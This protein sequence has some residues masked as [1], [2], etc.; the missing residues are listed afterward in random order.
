MMYE[1]IQSGWKLFTKP[2]FGG[3]G[4]VGH[5]DLDDTKPI[6]RNVRHPRNPSRKHVREDVGVGIAD[7]GEVMPR[8]RISREDP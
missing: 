8:Q 5:F 3:C 4:V 1:Y 2:A 6:I 7:L